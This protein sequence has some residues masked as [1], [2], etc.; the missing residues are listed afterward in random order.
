MA[1]RSPFSLIQIDDVY[2]DVHRIVAENKPVG[3]FEDGIAVAVLQHGKRVFAENFLWF[4]V[5]EARNHP[6]I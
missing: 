1:A 2:K 4:K 3:N 5:K 6:A